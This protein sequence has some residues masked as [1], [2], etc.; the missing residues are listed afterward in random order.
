MRYS[1]LSG[2]SRSAGFVPGCAV[3]SLQLSEG[4]GTRS[5]GGEAGGGATELARRRRGAPLATLVPGQ[6]GGSSRLCIGHQFDIEPSKDTVTRLPL[7]ESDR[8]AR[9]THC[10]VSPRQGEPFNLVTSSEQ[11]HTTVVL[12]RS[13]SDRL[14]S[15]R[16]DPLLHCSGRRIYGYLNPSESLNPPADQFMGI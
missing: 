4:S 6:G 16:A 12:R 11:A 5:S 3:C 1:L 2:L 8:L 10:L 15:P 7:E 9:S 13:I 14:E